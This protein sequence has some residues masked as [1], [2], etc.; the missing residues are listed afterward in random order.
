[1]TSSISS[2]TH[3]LLITSESLTPESSVIHELF[4]SDSEVTDE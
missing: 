3:D 2:L 1:M 4:M